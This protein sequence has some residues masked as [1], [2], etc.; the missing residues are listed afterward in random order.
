MV[1]PHRYNDPLPLVASVNERNNEFFLKRAGDEATAQSPDLPIME[2]LQITILNPQAKKLIED[3]A[4]MD[5][6]E[7]V[8]AGGQAEKKPV[9][10]FGCGK[11]EM[12]ILPSFYEPLDEFR[13]YE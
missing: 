12:V 6:I 8:S 2:T 3:L 7:I 13:E 10:H 11:G 9:R 4:E 5:L 1:L